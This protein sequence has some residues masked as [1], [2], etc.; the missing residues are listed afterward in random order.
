MTY[1]QGLPRTQGQSRYGAASL[2]THVFGL[3][4]LHTPRYCETCGNAAGQS[5]GTQRLGRVVDLANLDPVA[6]DLND[7]HLLAF[8]HE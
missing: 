5:D 3:Q 6:A 8:V 1:I 2:H 7:T 4:R